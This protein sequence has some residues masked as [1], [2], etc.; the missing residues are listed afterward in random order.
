[1]LITADRSSRDDPNSPDLLL[2]LPSPG[3]RDRI[4]KVMTIAASGI[5]S[6]Q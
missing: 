1:M 3:S 4:G 5:E 2:A 6:L